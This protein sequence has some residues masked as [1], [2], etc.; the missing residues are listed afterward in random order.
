MTDPAAACPRDGAALAVS[1]S[2]DVKALLCEQCHGLWLPY[3]AVIRAI[4]H[5]PKPQVPQGRATSLKCP[6]D[7]A[8]LSQVTHYGAEV[9]LCPDCSGVWLDR[10]EQEQ[11][12]ELYRRSKPPAQAPMAVS[13][14]NSDWAWDV[15]ERVDWIELLLQP[16]ILR[17]A[18]NLF[19]DASDDR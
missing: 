5:V 11:I 18:L 15:V 8:A 6:H 13:G 19:F 10:G 7:A 2:P 12:I 9:D 17:F 1:R 14:S 16:E 4:G 3:S